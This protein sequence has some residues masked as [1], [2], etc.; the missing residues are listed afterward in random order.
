MIYITFTGITKYS[1]I[2]YFYE[3]SENIIVNSRYV[4]EAVM[5][6]YGDKI[7]KMYVFV[8][9]AE[10]CEKNYEN[11]KKIV[12]EQYPNIL[13]N[14]IYYDTN[15]SFDEL[16][17]K[18]IQEINIGEKAKLILGISNTFRYFPLSVVQLLPY[19]QAYKGVNIKYIFNGKYNKETQTGELQDITDCYFDSQVI[20]Y[21][22][23]FKQTLR[24]PNQLENIY[25]DEIKK[26]LIEM[27]KINDERK[28]S[29]IYNELNCFKKIYLKSLALSETETIYKI[30]LKDIIS[31]LSWTQKNNIYVQMNDM[32]KYMLDKGYYQHAVTIL[33]CN[34]VVITSALIKGEGL[35][36]GKKIDLMEE[37][38]KLI[39]AID[40]RYEGEY[41][42]KILSE[43]TRQ[44][45]DSVFK[46]GVPT[47]CSI[48][49]FSD[50]RN[51]IDHGLSLVSSGNIDKI[52]DEICTVFYDYQN[53]LNKI[54]KFKK[55]WLDNPKYLYD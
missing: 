26:L 12:V 30:Y 50:I 23:Q 1:Q 51:I 7:N 27:R 40:G 6:Q 36:S 49:N 11:I 17:N 2:D 52:R 10:D 38:R 55:I 4:Q 42:E 41:K 14:K 8:T 45:M 48:K 16:L 22:V 33:D 15:I 24:V 53:K 25:N 46:K 13:I 32:A 34:R 20:R 9:N 39:N 35:F 19:I 29:N 21:L 31:E 5:K 3:N 47:T 18:I 54:A 37:S 43:E 44:R 28:H